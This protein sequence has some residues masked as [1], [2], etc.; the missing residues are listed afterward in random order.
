VS[1]DPEVPQVLY[2]AE[3]RIKQV[4]IN[5][6]NHAV[7]SPREGRVELRVES[8]EAD[9]DT[10]ELLISI[11]DTGMGIRKEDIPYLFDAFKRVDEG[12]NR[13]I[14]GTGLGLSIVKQLVELMDGQISV[15]SI[16]GEGSTFAV[17]IRQV[18]TDHTGVGELN[19][20]NQQVT[21]KG[22]HE[23]S[24]LAMDVQILIVD[25]NVMNLEVESR[26]LADT[27]M[28]IDTAVSGKQALDMCLNAHYD[29]IFMDHLMPEMDGIKCLEHIRDQAGG[30]NRNTPVIVLTA[31]AGSENRELY[32][33]A[34]F[35]GYLVKPVSG[36]AMEEMLIRHVSSEKIV[37]QNVLHGNDEDIKTTD[38]YAE[39]A[40]V[41]ITSSSM[42]D[43]PVSVLQKLHIPIIPFLIKTEDSV[44]LDG[45]QIDANELI[46]HVS[47]GGEGISSPP[48]EMDYTE[49]FAE[50]LKKAHHVIHISITMGL[51]NEFEIASEAARSFDNVSV[52]N[53]ESISS[54]TGILVLIAYK[55][56]QQGLPV[57][58]I[59]SELE[60]VK[61]LLRSSF[62]IDT[63]DYIAK[64]G[65]ISRRL[66]N[67]AR[68]INLHPALRIK[69]DRAV[70][71]G[72]WVGRTKHAYQRYLNSVIPSDASLNTDVAFITYVGVPSDILSWIREELEKKAH[73]EHIIIQQASAAISS[74][75]GPGAFGVL[76]F[77]KSKKTYNISAYMEE[78]TQRDDAAEKKDLTEES[79]EEYDAF[80]E[81]EDAETPVEE[82]PVVPVTPP[83]PKWYETLDCIDGAAAIKNSGSE[84]A[85]KTVL[86]IFYDSIPKKNAELEKAF[87]TEDW[88]T[89]TIKIHALKSSA[90]L[91]G[92][93]EL[94]DHAERL[95]M[96]G[97]GEDIS[98]IR[99]QH[100][101][102]MAEY[103]H[104]RE[105]LAPLYEEASGGGE[106]GSDK[107]VADEAL[108][109][110]VYDK[111]LEAAEEMDL[112][113]VEEAM[114]SLN[115]YAI[116]DSERDKFALVREKADQLDYDGMRDVILDQA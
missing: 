103:L 12:K 39:K 20:H 29:A 72:A 44:F 34:G 10:V 41:I 23:S 112:D 71:G 51:S 47:T 61:H 73:F 32:N 88:E 21:R 35:D 36:D 99:K 57:K 115:G 111:L 22:P 66:H 64:K 18:V 31:N 56:T 30:L 14:E 92:A 52:V 4:I 26:L 8:R 50:S 24:F 104:Y 58:D 90:R 98:Y 96:A 69:R 49:F 45:L 65:L 2:G 85:F 107:P 74:N 82:A 33:H 38:K 3:V 105:A 113:M 67:I 37:L 89:Y 25:D 19:I 27:G 48:D 114:E 81:T 53:S 109:K 17:R 97:K 108:M 77:L 1:V 76:Y 70:L 91:V 15:N 11:T 80:D 79:F 116:P 62:V 83:E 94:G 5:L 102:V 75:C 54:A 86:K 7:K 6:L 59:L 84:D 16:Y 100:A 106:G 42:C 60:D 46:R 87:T 93:L 28:I 13:H 78:I 110:Q 101:P 63:T 43:L 95:E 9:A 55:L 68:V 40:P